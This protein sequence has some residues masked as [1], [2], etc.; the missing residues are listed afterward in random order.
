MANY[1]SPRS[2]LHTRPETTRTPHDATFDQACR[3]YLHARVRDLFY[4]MISDRLGTAVDASTLASLSGDDQRKIIAAQKWRV[5]EGFTEI[6]TTPVR[7]VDDTHSICL[8][9]FPQWGL[10]PLRSYP[11]PRDGWSFFL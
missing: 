8:C 3:V 11:C 5:G 10:R 1:N 7:S 6:G 9:G 2:R 4:E